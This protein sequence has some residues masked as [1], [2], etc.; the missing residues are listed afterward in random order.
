M[1]FS[2]NDVCIK[3]HI[4]RSYR[5]ETILL[6]TATNSSNERPCNT[7]V[8]ESNC[9][10]NLNNELSFYVHLLVAIFYA[11]ATLT[12]F[13]K[14]ISLFNFKYWLMHRLLFKTKVN[15][16]TLCKDYD[17]SRSRLFRRHLESKI[18]EN[19]RFWAENFLDLNLYG[20]NKQPQQQQQPQPDNN[21]YL[22]LEMEN[23]LNEDERK[24]IEMID[25]VLA[26]PVETNTNTNTFKAKKN[27]KN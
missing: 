22:N 4:N 6:N 18:A 15:E 10:V 20:D 23:F 2:Y 11:T 1:S 19:E 24:A 8:S 14:M 7:N 26:R 25:N 12:F 17:D 13:L 5:N 3:Q 21:R 16:D 27:N 9:L